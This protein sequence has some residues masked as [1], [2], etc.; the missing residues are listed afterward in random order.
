MHRP[1]R[2]FFGTQGNKNFG[3]NLA[4][5]PVVYLIELGYGGASGRAIKLVAHG[6]ALHEP[7][8]E[9]CQIISDPHVAPCP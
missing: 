4:F 3:A 7:A 9:R 6:C 2:L 5:F 1:I 8:L